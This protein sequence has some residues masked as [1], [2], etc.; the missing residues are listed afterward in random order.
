MALILSWIASVLVSPVL[1]YKIIENK[2][3]KPD[4]EWTRRDYIMHRMKTVFYAHFE[5]LLHWALGHHKA[6]LLITLGAFILSLLSLPLIK[7][8]FFP[9]SSE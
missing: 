1:G 7:Q 2:A 9:S 4:S 3:E 6:V 8:E 5:S